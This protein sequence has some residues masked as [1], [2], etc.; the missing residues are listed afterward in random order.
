[1]EGQGGLEKR[2]WIRD[3]VPPEWG[4]DEAAGLFLREKE[5]KSVRERRWHGEK[6]ESMVQI[7]E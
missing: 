3:R 2:R 6:R 1:M 4:L 5:G 7:N